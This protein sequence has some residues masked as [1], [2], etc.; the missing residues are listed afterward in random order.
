[1][2]LAQQVVEG[3]KSAAAR[4]ISL[5]ES[6]D[7]EADEQLR[8]LAQHTGRA[9]V[10]GVTGAPGSGKST[11]VGRLAVEF[12][13]R[14][15]RVGVL[16]VDPSSPFSGGAILGD[17]VRMGE[18][19]GDPGVFVRS[20][21]GRGAAGGLARAAS[22]AIRVL[23][24]FGCNVIVV[25]TVGAGQ[26]EV[27]IARA[28]HSTVV[29]QVPGMGDG[30]Q[31]IKAGILEIADLF[32]VNKADRAGSDRL[33]TELQGML[34]MVGRDNGWLPPVLKTTATTGGGVLEV[35]ACLESHLG[36]LRDSGKLEERRL[37]IARRD[38]LQAVQHQLLRTMQSGPGLGLLEQ[39]AREILDR[40]TD[41]RSAAREIAEM[42][43]M[44]FTPRVHDDTA[45][46]EEGLVSR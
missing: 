16:A 18:L 12:R 43:C 13:S 15:K 28:S 38:L 9:H 22:D 33:S 40:R 1:V 26:D 4:L 29:V 21:A 10:V 23:D 8:L 27:E 34:E 17:R 2:E 45:G 7:D 11:L 3:N 6:E 30:L 20:M 25:E 24:A 35:V 36:Y 19:A 39:L 14:G 37:D 46:D 32:V 5:I 42:L 41:P 44:G 31:A